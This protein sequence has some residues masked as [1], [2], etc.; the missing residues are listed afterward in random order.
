MKKALIY[1]S[2]FDMIF[3]LLLSLSASFGTV[4]Y[5]FAFTVPVL[6]FIAI[7]RSVVTEPLNIKPTGESLALTLPTVAPTVAIVFAA[8]YL[9]SLLLSFFG[10][11]S[12]SPDV[13][14]N[15]VYAILNMPW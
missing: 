15:L 8:S 9:T 14:G 1:I 12:S 10:E 11:G 3:I 2:L 6:L 5:Y 7:R 4:F 13:S